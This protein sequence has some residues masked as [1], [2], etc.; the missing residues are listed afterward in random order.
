MILCLGLSQDEERGDAARLQ[1]HE[2]SDFFLLLE[3]TQRI[4]MESQHQSVDTQRAVLA[5][6]IML[7]RV[8]DADSQRSHSIAQSIGSVTSKSALRYTH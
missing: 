6:S 8:K 5:L 1:P 3:T 2:R 7:K 4:F